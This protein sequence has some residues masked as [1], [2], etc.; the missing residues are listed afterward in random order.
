MALHNK[1]FLVNLSLEGHNF[2]SWDSISDEDWQNVMNNFVFKIAD[3]FAFAGVSKKEDLFPNNLRYFA[4]WKLDI[5]ELVEV[6]D[7]IVCKF[8]LNNNCKAKLLQYDFAVHDFWNSEPSNYYE[9]DQLDFF[10]GERRIACY[11][12]HESEIMF[13]DLNDREASLIDNLAPLIKA[14]F[15][16]SAVL[17]A[18]FEAK[19]G[20]S[21]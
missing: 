6:D 12:N 4:D 9:F 3:S 10:I 21:N 13:F 20:K 15:I 8:L 2:P 17:K 16:D 11:I 7:D 18:V 14:S 19:M 1:S 5:I